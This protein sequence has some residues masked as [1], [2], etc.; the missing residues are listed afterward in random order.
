MKIGEQETEVGYHIAEKKDDSYVW[1][2]TD[3]DNPS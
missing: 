2:A 1:L 3:H